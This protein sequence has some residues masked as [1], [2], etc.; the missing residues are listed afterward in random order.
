MP[1]TRAIVIQLRDPSGVAASRSSIASLASLVA[2]QMIESEV[3]KGLADELRTS[4]AKNK[5]EAD[6]SVVDAGSLKGIVPASVASDG[7]AFLKG[8]AIGVGVAGIVALIY[9]ATTQR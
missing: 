5:A 7:P 8:L 1:T 2:P 9:S 6:V 3:Y 4:L